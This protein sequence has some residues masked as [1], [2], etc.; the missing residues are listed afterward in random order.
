LPREAQEIDPMKIPLRLRLC[1]FA[2]MTIFA[3]AMPSVAQNIRTVILVKVKVGQEDS[4]KS[5]V[6]DYV[7]LFKKAGSK[8]TITVWDSQTGP[9]Q[10]AV[11]FYSTK[12]QEMDEH[13][14]AMKGSEADMARGIARIS[15]VTD[16]LEY[17]IDEMQP[18]LTIRSNDIPPM[19]RTGRT[20]VISGKMDEVKAIFHD[21]LSPAIRKSGTSDWGVAYARFGTPSNEIHTYIGLKGW[22]DLDAPVGA[23]KGMTADEYKAFQAKVTP[24]IESTEYTI[25]K[26]AP[27]LSYLAPS[28]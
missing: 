21:V 20:K 28:K 12:W 16:S 1:L 13:D 11:V 23:Q 17:W 10:H 22:A 7:A 19:I 26:F 6:K 9:S 25:W 2:A 27:E 5:A 15:S 14:P 8:Q 24:L 3:F 18:D 4:W